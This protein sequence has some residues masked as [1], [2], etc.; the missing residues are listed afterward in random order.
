MSEQG[1][2]PKRMIKAAI[3]SKDTFFGVEMYKEVPRVGDYVQVKLQNVLGYQ[4]YGVCFLCDNSEGWDVVLQLNSVERGGPSVAA[5]YGALTGNRERRIYDARIRHRDRYQVQ[6]PNSAWQ[7]RKDI[8]ERM[9]AGV[10]AQDI[11]SEQGV[12][13]ARIKQLRS[14][15]MH[16]LNRVALYSEEET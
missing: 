11:A 12:N 5:F 6:N 13:V 3:F 15:W 2:T 9:E 4:V 1:E 16:L 8:Y 10:S 7:R 14:E